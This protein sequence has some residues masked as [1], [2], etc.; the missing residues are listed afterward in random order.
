MSHDIAYK[1]SLVKYGGY[2]YHHLLVNVVPRLR[3][4]GLDDAGSGGSSWR[5]RP[6]PSPSHD[7]GLGR[8]T[9]HRFGAGWISGVLSATCGALGYGGVLCLLF[10]N[11]L[12]TP[13]ARA[14]YRWT[15]S[16]S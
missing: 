16:A 11:W 10:P 6:A 13:S 15:W 4:K 14:L 3:A 5:I 7:P 12:T 2:G 1:T 9:G 8:G